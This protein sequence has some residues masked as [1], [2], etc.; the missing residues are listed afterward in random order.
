MSSRQNSEWKFP[1]EDSTWSQMYSTNNF[2]NCFK[3]KFPQGVHSLKREDGNSENNSTSRVWIF[4][5]T[6]V[7]MDDSSIVHKSLCWR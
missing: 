6:Q 1:T 2:V 5:M 3:T 4:C 7:E